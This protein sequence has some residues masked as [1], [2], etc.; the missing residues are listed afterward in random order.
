MPVRVLLA[1][2]AIALIVASLIDIGPVS[3]PIA[4]VIGVLVCLVLI[5]FEWRQR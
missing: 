5:A 1:L 2:A 4:V 3:A